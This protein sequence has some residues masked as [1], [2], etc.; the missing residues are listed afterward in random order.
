M[1]SLSSLVVSLPRC[2]DKRRPKKKKR[3]FVAASDDSQGQEERTSETGE[4]RGEN[5]VRVVTN[6][7]ENRTKIGKQ[8]R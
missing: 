6:L 5:L 8:D 4:S 2:E 3:S 7:H 1:G